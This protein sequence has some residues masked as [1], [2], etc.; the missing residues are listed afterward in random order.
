MTPTERVVAT[1]A[2]ALV[3]LGLLARLLSRAGIGR[4]W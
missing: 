1:I 2:V 3:V 4:W